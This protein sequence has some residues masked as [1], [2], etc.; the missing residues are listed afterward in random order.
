MEDCPLK[1]LRWFKKQSEFLEWL[2]ANGVCNHILTVMG[3]VT[4]WGKGRAYCT[5]EPAQA[6]SMPRKH[7]ICQCD[8]P[9]IYGF[10][11][12]DK[13]SVAHEAAHIVGSIVEHNAEHTALAWKIFEHLK[14]CD[15]CRERFGS[16]PNGSL[17]LRNSALWYSSLIIL[18]SFLALLVFLS[19]II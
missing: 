10:W 13:A 9:R 14:E 6:K 11:A 1:D 12:G 2:K 3:T 16:L 7:F 15:L 4:P 5:I 19:L 17:G 18:A 8:N